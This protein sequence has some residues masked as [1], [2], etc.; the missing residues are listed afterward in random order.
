MM[1]GRER[2]LIALKR[3]Q[4]DI[5]P[6]WEQGFNESSIIGIA[7]HFVDG[8][9]LPEPKLV[10]DMTEEER[11]KLL[12]GLITFVRELDL[13]GV[14][15]TSLAPRERLDRDHIRDALSVVYHLSQFGE[16]YPVDGP[17]REAADLK[18]FRMRLPEEADFLM[19]D[20]LR[21]AFPEKAVAYHMPGTFKLSWLLRGAMEKLLMDYILNPDLAHNLARMVTDHC[22]KLIEMAFD[23]GAD[24]II[25]EGDLAHNPS[26]LMSPAHYNEFIGPYH[27][28]ICECVHRVD[29]KIVKHSDGRLTPLLPGL[30]EAGFDGIHPIQPQCMDIGEIKREFGNQVCLLGN[31]DCSF[32]L[33]FGTPDEVRES[34][35]ETIARAAPGGGYILSSS[36]SIHPGCQPENYLA[37]VE[38]ARKY[39]TYPNLTEN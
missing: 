19:L 34:V 15:A 9:D 33:V 29:G 1:N 30:I 6:L 8:D 11:F 14:T 24:F 31:I 32:L 16:P 10:M 5:V 39:G 25:L 13:E 20:V 3:E 22:F 4:P 28:E 36:N 27:K 23:K 21:S 35:R 37:M 12:G 2:I 7:R 18:A 38:A 26:S 17:I